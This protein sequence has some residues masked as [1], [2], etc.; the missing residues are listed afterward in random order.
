VLTFGLLIN[1]VAGLGGP[2]GL[3]GS[4]GAAI[5]QEARARGGR[6]RGAERTLRALAAA[7]A[8]ARRVRWLTCSGEMGADTLR[9]AGIPAEVVATPH[10]PSGPEDTRRA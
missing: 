9:A 4:D 2:A 10:V 8:A 1:P 7:G 3:K 6:P 5:Q